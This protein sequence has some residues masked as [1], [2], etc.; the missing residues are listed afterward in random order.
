MFRVPLH[1]AGVDL[2]DESTLSMIGERLS[3]LEWTSVDGR[4]LATLHT[5]KQDPTDVAGVTVQVA[6]RIRHALPHATLVEVDQDL[7][8]VSDIAH[9]VGVTREAVRLWVDGR[10]GP[11]GFPPPA[12]SPGS[13]KVWRWARVAEWLSHNYKI[14]FGESFLSDREIA[15]IHCAISGVREPVDA[16]WEVINS[17]S[18]RLIGHP[19]TT[20]LTRAG[21]SSPQLSSAWRM[22]VGMVKQPPVAVEIE[23][24]ETGAQ[25]GS[26]GETRAG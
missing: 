10:R 9:R 19:D 4:V 7:V 20:R 14:D 11:G 24:S 25:S 3:D 1:V 16:E 2:T 5:D 8:S 15:Q 21:S 6:R 17:F 13:S 12:G 23:P 22:A 18:D 26:D